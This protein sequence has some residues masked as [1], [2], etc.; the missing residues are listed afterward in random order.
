MQPH[1]TFSVNLANFAL[2]SLRLPDTSSFRNWLS[3]PVPDSDDTVTEDQL[4]LID[5]TDEDAGMGKVRMML[6][7]LGCRVNLDAPNT[8]SGSCLQ[9]ERIS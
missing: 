5:D 1:K 4:R 2:T 8:V 6:V 7:K 9:H 3:P